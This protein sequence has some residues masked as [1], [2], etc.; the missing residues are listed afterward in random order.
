MSKLIIAESLT[1]A[2][3]LVGCADK[4]ERIFELKFG[5]DKSITCSQGAAESEVENLSNATKGILDSLNT[6]SVEPNNE[7]DQKALDNN[8]TDGSLLAKALEIC[9]EITKENKGFFEKVFFEY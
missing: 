1:A 3:V 6:F 4:P 7:I 2:F 8:I 5:K 9:D